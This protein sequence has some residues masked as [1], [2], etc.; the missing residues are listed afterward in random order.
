MAIDHTSIL[1]RGKLGYIILGR[2]GTGERLVTD[3]TAEDVRLGNEKG[4]YGMNDLNR[5]GNAIAR[6]CDRLHALGIKADVSPKT[7]WQRKDIPSTGQMTDYLGQVQKIRDA[8]AVYRA[9][10]ETPAGMLWL[11]RTAANDIEKILLDVD[12]LITNTIA[13]R[14]YSGDLYGGEV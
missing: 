9:T 10:P 13:A 3:R 5:V 12:E 6:I 1:G 8:V 4:I 11:T 14:Y 2:N 7:D